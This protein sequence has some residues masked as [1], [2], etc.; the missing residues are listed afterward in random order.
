MRRRLRKV[1]ACTPLRVKSSS[2]QG[3][4]GGPVSDGSDA[5][6]VAAGVGGVA[7]AGAGAT[8]AGAG[9]AGAGVGVDS[10]ASAVG[11]AAASAAQT[12]SMMRLCRAI[13]GVVMR[14]REA[15]IVTGLRLSV[16]RR[17]AAVSCN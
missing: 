11:V 3:L 17:G 15:A 8:G 16:E 7:A 4:L 5:V 14:G 9:S 13:A 12:R 6:A 1:L 2:R 10:C